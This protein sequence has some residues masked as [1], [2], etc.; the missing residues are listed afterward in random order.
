MNPIKLMKVIKLDALDRKVLLELWNNCRQPSTVTASKLKT[1]RELIDYHI[2]KL[3]KAG[4]IYGYNVL[5]NSAML[6]YRTYYLHIRLRDISAEREQKILDYLTEHK[7]IK[8]VALCSGRWDMIVTIVAK[9]AIHL[10]PML[11]EISDFIG[12]N[13]SEI[14]ANPHIYI[15]KPA[16]LPIF[17][18]KKKS[19]FENQ[20]KVSVAELNS[21]DQLDKRLLN[22]LA[23]DASISLVQL[24]VKTKEL[25]QTIS[26]RIKRMEKSGLIRGYRAKVNL[27]NLGYLWYLLL[28]G[29]SSL[30][31]KEKSM[32]SSLFY[33]MPE[34]LYAEKVMGKWN[35]RVEVASLNNDDFRKSFV[36][37]RTALSK[38]IK[39]YDLELIFRDYKQLSM[40]KG[41]LE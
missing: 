20:K 17:L 6:G 23:E 32:L 24:S 13:L 16:G 4:I 9:D 34:I 15:I 10:D 14:E 18:P 5:V 38:L 22:L 26:Y 39:Y 29:L 40:P 12:E 2:K 3:E 1:S 11:S 36:N 41:M 35:L 27:S 25:P 8:W 31:D 33:T 30:S 19:A 28:F 7:F 21:L 37:I